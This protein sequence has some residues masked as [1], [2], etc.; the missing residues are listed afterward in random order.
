MKRPAKPSST[1]NRKRRKE[2]EEKKA[3][4][5]GASQTQASCSSTTTTTTTTLSTPPIFSETWAEAGVRIKAPDDPSRS[6]KALR[7]PRLGSTS[8]RGS[9]IKYLMEN[10]KAYSSSFYAS[11]PIYLL[12]HLVG[13]LCCDQ[14]LGKQT[15]PPSPSGIAGC[16]H[17]GWHRDCSSHMC[18][19]QK[20]SLRKQVAWQQGEGLRQGKFGGAGGEWQ[21]SLD[22]PCALVTL[23]CPHDL[24]FPCDHIFKQHSQATHT[25]SCH[26]CVERRSLKTRRPRPGPPLENCC[27]PSVGL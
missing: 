25:P 9:N 27:G 7:D 11:F 18:L 3:K 8:P 10:S 13:S 5:K 22:P 20:Y 26:V 19:P 6:M 24:L 15:L 21:L 2:K 17:A 1:Q 4:H 16:P 14:S 12:P 23:Q